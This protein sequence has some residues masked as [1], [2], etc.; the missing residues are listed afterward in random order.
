MQSISTV[1]PTDVKA[2]RPP[3]SAWGCHEKGHPYLLLLRSTMRNIINL[4]EYRVV[5]VDLHQS[6]NRHFRHQVAQFNEI[7]HNKSP[8]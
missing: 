7:K 6:S 2:L 3:E 1:K 8:S 4:S 5:L